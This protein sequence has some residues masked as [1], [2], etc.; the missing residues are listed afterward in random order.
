MSIPQN[1]N[2]T[3]TYIRFTYETKSKNDWYISA[4]NK[5]INRLIT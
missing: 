3:P 4:T 1:V 5:P 2:I